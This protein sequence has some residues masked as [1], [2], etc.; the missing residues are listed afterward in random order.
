MFSFSCLWLLLVLIAKARSSLVFNAV[1]GENLSESE[2]S[3]RQV[4]I[5]YFYNG[6]SLGLIVSN[7]F[8]TGNRFT[9]MLQPVFVFSFN[10][11]S[12]IECCSQS[13]D[14]QGYVFVT[15]CGN[16]SLK[17]QTFP[18]LDCFSHNS[19]HQLR[20]KRI[21]IVY[22]CLEKDAYDLKHNFNSYLKFLWESYGLINVVIFPVDKNTKI[23]SKSVFTYN[24]FITGD[25]LES[26]L[27]QAEV[28]ED[29]V[30][31]FQKRFKNM[32]GYNIKGADL[33]SYYLK[34][35]D[36]NINAF[37]RKNIYTSKFF[38]DTLEYAFNMTITAL[39]P[40]SKWKSALSP[41][42]ITYVSLVD[43][44]NNNM[45]DVA[46]TPQPINSVYQ[47]I[48]YLTSKSVEPLVILVKKPLP[49]GSWKIIFY[50]FKKDLWFKIGFAYTA[51]CISAIFLSIFQV[52]KKISVQ[53]DKTTLDF[54]RACSNALLTKPFKKIP[55]ENSERLFL[56]FCLWLG[57]I[58]NL[59]LLGQVVNF[60]YTRPQPPS[61]DTFEDLENSDIHIYYN[62]LKSY[63]MEFLA[64][65]SLSRLGKKLHLE[66]APDN[67]SNGKI[68]TICFEISAELK[69]HCQPSLHGKLHIMNQRVISLPMFYVM[70]KGSILFEHF[71]LLFSKLHEAGFFAYWEDTYYSKLCLL[72]QKKRQKMFKMRSAKLLVREDLTLPFYALY[73]GLTLSAICF[74]LEVMSSKIFLVIRLFDV[75]ISKNKQHK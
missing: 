5:K 58:V 74:I 35:A 22:N 30:K 66:L 8:E 12:I 14:I 71:D 43:D 27:V 72:K 61:V 9:K 24:P 19:S 49:V 63:N 15:S 73:I 25:T 40:I 17:E 20:S 53:R 62:E 7:R 10:N 2:N 39:K 41:N 68:G 48:Q 6:S 4:I 32:N 64:N 38:R 45:V 29:F 60:M 3:L 59:N 18:A 44:V 36:C 16:S 11:N 21:L 42:L 69:L 33:D 28:D 31:C 75:L 55:T 56:G 1:D 57:F 52:S 37:E 13:L 65:T 70:P 47:N 26:G 67:D 46:L 54:L 23:V 34:G 50:A 51:L